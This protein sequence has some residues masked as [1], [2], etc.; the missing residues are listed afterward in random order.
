MGHLHRNTRDGLRSIPAHNCTSLHATLSATSPVGVLDRW[1]S[2]IAK[3]SWKVV[4]THKRVEPFPWFLVLD[5]VNIRVL[6]R[7]MGLGSLMLEW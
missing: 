1:T 7:P 5:V 2:P 4:W 3:A 6:G